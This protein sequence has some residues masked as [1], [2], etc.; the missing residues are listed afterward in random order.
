[1]RL[2]LKKPLETFTVVL[3]DWMPQRVFERYNEALTANMKM[4]LN[5]ISDIT[6][7][8][9]LNA[10]GAS[11][12]ANFRNER[13]EEK[14]NAMLNEV[15]KKLATKRVQATFTI[16]DNNRAQRIKIV[17]MISAV[18][19]KNPEDGKI[20]SISSEEEIGRFID[21]MPTNL[22]QAVADA[23]EKIEKEAEKEGK[24]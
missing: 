2:A 6:D 8:E 5:S 24:E 19:D 1:M 20:T 15:R 17:G 16:A 10:M 9:I 11:Y 4:D 3:K 13:D 14:K 12:L 7:D 22:Y 18:E 23:I 21:E